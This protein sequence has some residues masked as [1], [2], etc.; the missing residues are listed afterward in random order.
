MESIIEFFLSFPFL[1]E[2]RL[3]FGHRRLAAAAAAAANN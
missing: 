2:D 3:P 1:S